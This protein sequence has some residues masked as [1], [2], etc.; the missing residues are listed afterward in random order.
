MLKTIQQIISK[1]FQRTHKNLEWV[2]KN[3]S[4]LQKHRENIEKKTNKKI[5]AKSQRT[6]KT[7]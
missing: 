5:L 4:S 3:L 2:L 1:V 7:L 6:D